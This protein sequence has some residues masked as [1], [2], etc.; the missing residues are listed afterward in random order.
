VHLE[1]TLRGEVPFTRAAASAELLLGA[2]VP[3]LSQFEVSALGGPGFGHTP[4]TPAWRALLGLAWT[5]SFTDQTPPALV[6]VEG[7]PYALKDCPALDLD[8]DGVAN[9]ADRCPT[10]KGVAAKAGCPD[11]DTDGDGVKDLADACPA[12][13]GLA[14]FKGCPPPDADGDGLDDLDD[15]CPKEP[16]P[17]ERRGCPVKDQ[18]HDGIEDDVDACPTEKGVAEL[19]GCPDRDGDGDGVVDRLDNCPKE[20]GPAD[21]Q[22]CPKANKQLVVITAEKIVIKDKVFFATGKSQ[23]LARSFPL[24][25]QVANVLTGHPELA[26]LRIEGHT[27]DRGTHEANVTLS[28]SRADAVKAFLINAGVATARLEA[29]GFGPD[30]PADTNSTEKGRENNRRVEFL[31]VQE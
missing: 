12:V 1:A 15:Q 14:E 7:K 4:G 16:G 13:K 22:G 2:R 17:L 25:K 26:H 24:L 10:E 6:C 8:G 23:I 27:D 18:D 29:K 20:A 5:P 28:Q 31:V 9:G 3:F 19:K 11:V 21:N 30:R